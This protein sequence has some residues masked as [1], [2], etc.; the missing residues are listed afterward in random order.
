MNI[1][2][3]KVLE[4][5]ERLD[6][7]VMLCEN[8]ITQLEMAE[9]ILMCE[10][11]N[12]V[13]NSIIADL[14]CKVRNDLIMCRKAVVHLQGYKA[15]FL[16]LVSEYGNRDA[17]DF[18]NKC[19]T[20]STHAIVATLIKQQEQQYT[21]S[22]VSEAD[23]STEG[24]AAVIFLFT[25]LVLFSIVAVSGLLIAEPELAIG[26]MMV[27]LCF[28]ALF[29]LLGNEDKNSANNTSVVTVINML[30]PQKIGEMKVAS[31]PP[32]PRVKH[33]L[34]PPPLK[35]SPDNWNIDLDYEE[36]VKALKKLR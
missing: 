26:I 31:P 18:D 10:S 14:I 36:Y 17:I 33:P 23:P 15:R 35:K 16:Q 2:E 21:K 22:L 7:D 25:G 5:L 9:N 13:T 8:R 29:G 24:T 20:P 34:V 27:G 3:S 32:P 28:A 11:I 12:D 19:S 1:E 30:K 4:V 6:K